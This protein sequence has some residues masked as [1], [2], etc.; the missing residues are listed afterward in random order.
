MRMGGEPSIDSEIGA[1][2]N[3]FRDYLLSEVCTDTSP[4]KIFFFE[5]L[6]KI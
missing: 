4:T 2:R 5:V 6:F 1:G 3:T